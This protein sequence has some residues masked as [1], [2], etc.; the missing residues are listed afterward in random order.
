MVSFSRFRKVG[1]P[2]FLLAAVL[3]GSSIISSCSQSS[4]VP[5]SRQR[6]VRAPLSGVFVSKER[7][8]RRPLAIVVDNAPEARPQSGLNKA[9]LVYETY[10]EGGI[11]RYLAVFQENDVKEIGPV[12]SARV[13]FVHWTNELEAVFGHVGGSEDALNLIPE[14]G[15][16]DL[17]EFANPEAYTR[18][19][20]RFAPHNTYT[21]TT[22]MRNAAE[23]RGYS[24][25]ETIDGFD[26]KNDAKVSARPKS[27]KVSVDFSG[28]P[29]AVDWVYDN[30][31]NSYKRF[32]DGAPDKDKVTRRQLVAKNVIVQRTT[33][34]DAPGGDTQVEALGSGQAEY[35]IDGKRTVGTWEKTSSRSRTKYMDRNGKE[36]RL[37][38]G[39]T[40]IEVERE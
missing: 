10:A 40:W 6:N 21:S 38:G 37:N 34:T 23:D 24:K 1:V 3:A 12:R 39:T 20:S 18:D 13:E 31:T 19:D 7:A 5:S 22:R 2:V 28:G 8:G 9:S 33:V 30:K 26:F 4:M 32:L 17:D 36:M 27:Q 15:V 25:Q 14:V 11:T 29:F 16:L 35:F